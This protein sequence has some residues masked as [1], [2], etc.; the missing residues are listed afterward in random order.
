MV[1]IWRKEN[2]KSW[3]ISYCGSVYGWRKKK[4]DAVVF[5]KKLNDSLFGE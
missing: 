1:Y 4:S 2:K 5:A 3:F